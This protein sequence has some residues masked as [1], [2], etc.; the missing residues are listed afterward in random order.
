MDR[1]SARVITQPDQR[2]QTWV[3]MNDNTPQFIPSLDP[4]N[5]FFSRAPT[6]YLFIFYFL[7]RSKVLLLSVYH[8][9]LYK[10]TLHT[11]CS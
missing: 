11:A 6:D 4:I 3:Q 8:M 7:S 2:N 5:L 1:A 10:C 9:V